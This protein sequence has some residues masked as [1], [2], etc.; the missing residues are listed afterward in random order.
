MVPLGRGDQEWQKSRLSWSLSDKQGRYGYDGGKG[1]ADS[2]TSTSRAQGLE[3]TQMPG[4]LMGRT[5][6]DTRARWRWVMGGL[7]VKTE[8][9]TSLEG[10][11]EPWREG[12]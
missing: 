4:R 5:L 6:C 9:G 1:I 12:V 11:E 2:K 8:V 3:A 10:D 7:G